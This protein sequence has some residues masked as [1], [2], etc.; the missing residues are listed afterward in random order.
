MPTDTRLD[1]YRDRVAS[2]TGESR[3]F[4][5][6]LILTQHYSTGTGGHLWWRQWADREVAV[7]HV[8]TL[9]GGLYDDP[10][11]DTELETELDRWS[12]DVASPR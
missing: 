1:P 11:D 6:V 5:H 10:V 8:K 3:I 9:D 12:R 4:G 2:L 7:P